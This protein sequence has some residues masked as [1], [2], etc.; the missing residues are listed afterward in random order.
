MRV[1]F[2]VLARLLLFVGLVF[3]VFPA[4]RRWLGAALHGTDGIVL[5][6]VDHMVELAAILLFGWIAATVE[7]R[8]LASFGLPWRR[9]L[10]RE[11]WQGAAAAL[12]SLTLLM[13]VL[14]LLGAVRIGAPS[15]TLEAAGLGI[16]Y[17]AIFVLLALR[18][19][20][21]YRGYGLVTLTE[22]IGFWGAAV[23]ST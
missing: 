15:P 14:Q 18:E 19:E 11:F 22:G 17:A 12:V 3:G 5:Y 21:L 10:R 7:D 1:R 4:K 16:A 20:F 6:L 9:A 13:V 2:G 23:A 8:S